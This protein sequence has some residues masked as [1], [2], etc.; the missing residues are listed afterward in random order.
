MRQHLSEVGSSG[1]PVALTAPM[2]GRWR[3]RL[4][5]PHGLAAAAAVAVGLIALVLARDPLRRWVERR[6]PLPAEKRVAVLPIDLAS[7]DP[8]DR[9]RSDGLAETLTARLAQLEPYHAGLSVV[10]ASDV[11]QAGVT[12]VDAARRTFGATLVVAARLARLGNQLRLDAQLVD[13]TGSRVLRRLPPEDHPLEA[14]SLQQGVV[15]AVAGLLELKVAPGERRVLQQGNTAVGG[16]FALYLQARGHLQRFERAENL[17]N[18]LSLLQ[19]ALEQDPGYAL[20]YAALG[21]AYWRLYELQKR[22]E[23]VALAQENCRKAIGLNDLLAPVHVTLGMIHRGTG[24]ADEALADLQRAL[25]RDPRS[26]E[27]LREKG[28]AHSALGQ[29]KEAEQAFRDALELRPS[30]WATHNYLGALMLTDGRLE[31]AEAEFRRVIALTPDNPRG[32]TNAGAV[33]FRQGR[34]E[35]AEA[36]FRRSAEIRPTASALSN[37]GTTLYYRGRYGEAAEALEKAAKLNDRQMAVWLNLGRTLY[38][39]P[40]RRPDARAPLERAV[41]LAEEQLRVNPRDAA[42]LADLADAHVMLGHAG[43]AS[44][45]SARALKLA[46]DDGDVLRT[47]AE[48][49]EALGRREAALQKIGRAL[50]AGYPR[51]QVERS[52]SLAAL[53]EDPRF[54]EVLKGVA[55]TPV[56]KEKKPQ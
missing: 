28:R 21:E 5:P 38:E 4:R 14:L 31:A 29:T 26:A 51:W 9:F 25:D 52:P 42:L 40:A 30:D 11:R 53:R 12:T 15:E 1:A 47:I 49:D 44:E 3:A 48:V 23:L 46:P 27:A 56:E 43:Q 41:A 24:K 37:L 22:P 6:S 35:D 39:S 55:P 34:L 10:P 32:Y 33:C 16:A 8:E 20:A 18:A 7:P 17:E 19:K 13:G 2:S 45:L 54:A 50:A 36:L